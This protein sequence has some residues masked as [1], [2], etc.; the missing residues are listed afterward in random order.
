ML[1]IQVIYLEWN[2]EC[3]GAPYS[4]IRSAMRCAFELP[5]NYTNYNSY[6][7]YEYKKHR[8]YLQQKKE[9]FETQF[10]EVIYLRKKSTL[11]I[12]NVEIAD[13]QQGYR[14]VFKYT[15]NI[16]K[17]VRT[18]KDR[19][20]KESFNKDKESISNFLVEPIGLLQR[21][22]YAR[23]MYNGR[24]TDFDTGAW[25]Y[26][27]CII[28]LFN[29]NGNNVPSDILIRTEPNIIYTQLARLF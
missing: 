29:Y 16:G 4:S 19:N 23:I 10:N 24:H 2:K 22:D 25:Y 9:G 13:N 18:F 21:N 14:I 26:S 12:A 1:V 5:S 17:S 8:I 20:F 3:R 15:P 27:K 28:N 6:S 11:N 7:I